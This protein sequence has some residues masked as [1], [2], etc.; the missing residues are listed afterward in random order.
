MFNFI[1]V[2]HILVCILLALIILMQS[3]RGGG[4]TEG[5]AAAES[6]FGAKTNV[7]L[8]RAT[9]VLASLFLATCLSL[10]FLSTQKSKS[11]IPDEP[12]ARSSKTHSAGMPP[13]A[14][15]STS[16]ASKEVNIPQPAAQDALPVAQQNQNSEEKGP[17][18]QLPQSGETTQP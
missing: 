6:M 18:Q 5:F 14:P 3:G 1:I 11:L 8:V 2:V 9:T 13:A 12:A 4:L 10:A 17:S 15:A 7:V 16:E